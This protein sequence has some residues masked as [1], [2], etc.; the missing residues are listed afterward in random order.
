MIQYP[1]ILKFRDGTGRVLKN[2]VWFG[3]GTK[4]PLGPAYKQRNKQ[5]NKVMI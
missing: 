1:I 2:K 5:A 4:I 3:S